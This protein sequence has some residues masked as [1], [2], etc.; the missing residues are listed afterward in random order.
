MS[1]LLKLNV[2]GRLLALA[3]FAVA[4]LLM[5]TAM[6]ALTV[7]RQGQTLDALVDGALA[8]ERRLAQA[9]AALGNTR[10]FEKDMFLNM[11]SAESIKHYEASWS[12][13]VASVVTRIDEAAP[14]LS[15]ADKPELDKLRAG[16]AGYQRGV[17]T[18]LASIRAGSL[19]DPAAANKAMTPYKDDVRTADKA[20]EALS[21]AVATRVAA[22]R[23]EAQA[24]TTTALWAAVAVGLGV[25]G[26]MLA[27]ALAIARSVIQPLTAATLAAERIAT[28]D[29]KQG[30]S[31]QGHDELALIGQAVEKVR[32]NVVRLV[33]DAKTL[34]SAAH[35]GQLATRIDTTHHAGDYREVVLGLN[36]TLAAVDAPLQQV[37]DQLTR[38]S[39]GNLQQQ[40]VAGHAGRFAEL[41]QAVNTTVGNLSATIAEVVTLARELGTA[42]N[43]VSVTSQTLSESASQQA[44]CVEETTASLHEILSSVQQNA[45]SAA[46]TDSIATEAAQQAQDGSQAVSQTVDAMKSIATKITIIDDIAYQTNLLALNAAIEA[47]RAGEHG[48]GFAVV[49]AEVRKLAERSQVA[50]QEI[51]GLATSSVKMAEQA[52]RMLSSMVPS[53]H[54]TSELVQ[55]ISAASGEQSNSVNQINGAMDHLNGT[56]QQTATAS[57]ELSATAEELSVQATR[58]QELMAFFQLDSTPSRAGGQRQAAGKLPKATGQPPLRFGNRGHAAPAHGNALAH[59]PSFSPI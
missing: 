21:A 55:E 41:G 58:L 30:Q 34:A 20:F 12:K 14:L 11:A 32:Q 16:L 7:W 53:I 1:S 45:S 49:A 2:R 37:L 28:G 15:S 13:S 6:Q 24:Q 22:R 4:A 31:V 10:R 54:K 36:Q 9:Q 44:A 29:L 42:S 51:G 39:Q 40:S 26:L 35:Q 23:A 56:T 50:A 48:K 46:T 17:T 38:V 59:E 27:L 25:A 19:Q 47:A 18:V 43:Q 8:G 52:G 3:L 33:D 5:L 57:E